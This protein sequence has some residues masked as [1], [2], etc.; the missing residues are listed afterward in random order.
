MS[1]IALFLWQAFRRPGQIV[2]LAPSGAQMAEVM[3]RGIDSVKGPIIE[4][5]PGT[6]VITRRILSRGIAAERLILLEMNAAFCDALRAEFPGVK[7][8]NTEAQNIESLGLSD[9]GAVVSGVP[10][11][12]RPQVQRDI[13]GR[14]F[15]VMRPEGRFIQFTYANRPPIST[16]VQEELGVKAELLGRVWKNLPPARVYAFTRT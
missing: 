10:I 2:A 6:G 7:I 1:N 14:A 3:T 15:K 16:D 4:I 9:V 8:I 13:V 5:G 12:A 11:L